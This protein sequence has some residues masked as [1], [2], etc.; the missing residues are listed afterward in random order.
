MYAQHTPYRPEGEN[1]PQEIA[2]QYGADKTVLS[3]GRVQTPTLAMLVQRQ[4]EID[5]FK[6]EDY[7]ELKTT[8]REIVFTSAIDRLKQHARPH[9]I[10][11]GAFGVK[12]PAQPERFR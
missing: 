4:K 7:W 1:G 11:V 8:Y 9:F 10:Q 12:L 2:G 3:I 5:A 6:P